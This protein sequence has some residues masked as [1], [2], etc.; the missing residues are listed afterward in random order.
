MATSNVLNIIASALVDI[1]PLLAQRL[2]PPQI[3]T[4]A[5]FPRP[6]DYRAP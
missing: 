3:K 5:G 6:L 2:Q 1:E 4:G